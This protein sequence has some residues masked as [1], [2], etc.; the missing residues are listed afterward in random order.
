MRHRHLPSV[1]RDRPRPPGNPLP[2]HHPDQEPEKL[3]RARRAW[4]PIL[5]K[6][7][8]GSVSGQLRPRRQRNFWF[9]AIAAGW[10]NR[11]DLLTDLLTEFN[12]HEGHSAVPRS[13][14]G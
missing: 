6:T 9:A 4:T 10:N 7:T 2:R 1:R 3:Y 11:P 12:P 13:G 8:A 5:P 14:R